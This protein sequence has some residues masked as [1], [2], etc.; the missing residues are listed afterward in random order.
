MNDYVG[1]ICPYCKCKFE[2]NDE[3]VVCSDC[4]MP[5]HK[6]CWIE[7]QGCTTFGCSGTI[8]GI[9]AIEPIAPI[10]GVTGEVRTIYCSQ[11]GEPSASNVLFCSKCGN[12]LMDNTPPTPPVTP[13][14]STY[15][16]YNS[17]NVVIY[18]DGN[19]KYVSGSGSSND[20]YMVQ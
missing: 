14:V 12:R 15:N 9:D 13:V 10:S 19:Q 18:I 7:N 17:Y 16:T 20:P 3:V 11:C 1:K 8:Q 2:E 6:D 5:H 4:E